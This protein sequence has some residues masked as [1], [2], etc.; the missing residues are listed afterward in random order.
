MYTERSAG[1]KGEEG[2]KKS[3]CGC[4]GEERRGWERGLRKCMR[5]KEASSSSG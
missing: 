4:L 3:G 1:K 2:G 5:S